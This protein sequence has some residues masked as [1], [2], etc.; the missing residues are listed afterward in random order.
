VIAAAAHIPL[1]RFSD[2][3]LGRETRKA[4]LVGWF[5]YHYAVI[6]PHIR[7]VVMQMTSGEVVGPLAGE[8]ADWAT[9]HPDS[10]VLQYLNSEA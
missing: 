3:R 7:N 2:R 1:P 6:G 8:F 5:N 4:L 10:E 9:A